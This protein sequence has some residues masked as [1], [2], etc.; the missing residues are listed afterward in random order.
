MT[1]K[2]YEII[3]KALATSRPPDNKDGRLWN[4]LDSSKAVIDSLAKNYSNFNCLRFFI[5]AGW[6]ETEV[7]SVLLRE[8]AANNLEPSLHA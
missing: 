2:D 8:A 5:A 7:A 4:W 1:H 6:K 3:A